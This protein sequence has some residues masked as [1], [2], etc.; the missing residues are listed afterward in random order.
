M[1]IK[2]WTEHPTLGPLLQDLARSDRQMAEWCDDCAR[3][4]PEE[5]AYTVRGALTYCGECA[6]DLPPLG[7]MAEP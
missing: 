6:A 7:P 1:L 3:V 2:P 5:V 4:I